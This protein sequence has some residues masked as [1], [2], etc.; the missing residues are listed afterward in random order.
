[1]SRLKFITIRCTNIEESRK[2]Y[3]E[4]V[5]LKFEKEKH[6]NG[7]E[8]Y[9]ATLDNG[10]VFELYPTLKRDLDVD[11]KPIFGFQIEHVNEELEGVFLL[12]PDDNCNIL[13]RAKCTCP[14][15]WFPP[16]KREAAKKLPHN[17]QGVL[18]HHKDCNKWFMSRK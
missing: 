16:G 4:V 2:F 11:R 3:E 9:A 12:D 1:M 18:K 14:E 13:S 17:Y 6:G 15:W 7:P 8:H 5:G 10:I